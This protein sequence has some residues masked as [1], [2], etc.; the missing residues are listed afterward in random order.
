MTY[1]D[2]LSTPTYERRFFLNMFINENNRRNEM[3]EEEAN[4]IRNNSGGGGKGTRTSTISGSQLK[5]KLLNGEIS[6]D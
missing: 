3:M 2:V 4:K 5:A 6:N 1:S